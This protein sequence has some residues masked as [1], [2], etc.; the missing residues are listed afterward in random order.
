MTTHRMLAF[1]VLALVAAGCAAPQTRAVVAPLEVDPLLVDRPPAPGMLKGE[2]KE[3]PKTVQMVTAPATL[4]VSRSATPAAKTPARLADK[5]RAP[6][7]HAQNDAAPA[8]KTLEPAL[9]IASLKIRL[10]DTK[11]IGVMT[12][13]ALKNQVDDLMQRFRAHYQGDQNLNVTTL[14]PSYDMLVLKVLAVV[15]DGD[16]ALAHT[17]AASREAIWAILADRDKFNAIA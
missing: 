15:Q 14:R 3:A 12:K 6:S 4:V 2:P 16:P 8:A 5:V 9:D 7:P 11:A 13:L 17:I 1:A 10:R